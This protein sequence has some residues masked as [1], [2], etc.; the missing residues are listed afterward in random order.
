[1][2]DYNQS[3]IDTI[4]PDGLTESLFATC[5]G[6]QPAFIAFAPVP[7]PS[8][9]ALLAIAAGSLLLRRR[10]RGVRAST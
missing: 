6:Y 7:E 1:M 5:L 8:S 3:R 10:R 2:A 4:S 9:F